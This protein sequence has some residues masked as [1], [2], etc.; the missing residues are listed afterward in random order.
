[1]LLLPL[2]SRLYLFSLAADLSPACFHASRHAHASRYAAA[3]RHFAISAVLRHVIDRLRLLPISPLPRAITPLP[4]PRFA[5]ACSPDDY[6]LP[7]LMLPS[8]LFA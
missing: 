4:L 6:A 5:F 3:C 2:F 7:P 1:M 8:S